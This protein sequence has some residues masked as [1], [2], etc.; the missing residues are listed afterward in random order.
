M[1]K[2]N[3]ELQVLLGTQGRRPWQMHI[4]KLTLLWLDDWDEEQIT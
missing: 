1:L 3:G 4:L 2:E